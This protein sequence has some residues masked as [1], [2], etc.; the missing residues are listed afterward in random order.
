MRDKF[1]NYNKMANKAKKIDNKKG[2][3]VL[4]YVST[5]DFIE[6][7]K[8]VKGISST[9]TRTDNEKSMYDINANEDRQKKLSSLINKYHSC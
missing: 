2:N 3:G 1:S 8:I 6:L 7:L 4:P 9:A 5:S